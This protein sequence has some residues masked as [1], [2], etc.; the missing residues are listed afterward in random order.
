[1][2]LS[3]NE[4]GTNTKKQNMLGYLEF[5]QRVTEYVQASVNYFRVSIMVVS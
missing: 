4:D 3:M 2:I 5:H 1:M